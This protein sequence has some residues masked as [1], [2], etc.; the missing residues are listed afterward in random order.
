MPAE[1]HTLLTVENIRVRV[2][3]RLLVDEL[4]LSLRSG[5]FVAV[6]GQNGAGKTLTMMTLAGLRLP[7]AGRVLLQGVD[8]I[9]SRRQQTARRLALLPQVVDDIFPATVIDTALIGRH[10]HI[11]R[12]R[13]ES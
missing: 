8:I 7:E 4:D 6:L 11:G 2:P 3:G 12:F 9:Q 10:P 1:Y 13:W 5:E